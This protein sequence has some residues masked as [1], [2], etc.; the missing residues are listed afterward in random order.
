MNHSQYNNISGIVN[1]YHSYYQ[2]GTEF[3]K[4]YYQLWD[5]NFPLIGNLFDKNIKITFLGNHFNNITSLVNSNRNYGIW[6]FSHSNIYKQYQPIDDNTILISAFGTLCINN[7][8]YYRKFSETIIIRRNI[9]G[10]W[11]ITNL[12]F[13]LIPETLF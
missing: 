4:Y 1:I 13:Q 12:V 6:S 2:I 7:N 5:N 9:W 11:F 10:N 3:C 8:N